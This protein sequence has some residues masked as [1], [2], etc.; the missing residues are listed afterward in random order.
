MILNEKVERIIWTFF[1]DF[2][3]KNTREMNLLYYNSSCDFMMEI[4]EKTIPNYLIH[5]LYWS[6]TIA[7]G[8]LSVEDSV[9]RAY[10]IISH[11]LNKTHITFV[12]SSN[13][14]KYLCITTIF[15]IEIILVNEYFPVYITL[16]LS[17]SLESLWKH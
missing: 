8:L 14:F 4:S 15:S 5:F 16:S 11:R 9:E 2:L 1:I 7:S 10:P 3:T 17:P 6:S 12:T 13:W